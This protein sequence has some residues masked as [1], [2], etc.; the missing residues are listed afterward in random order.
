MGQGY[1]HEFLIRLDFKSF[2]ALHRQVTRLF[3]A[4]KLEEAYT[5]MIAAQGNE[6]TLKEWV[7]PWREFYE[8]DSGVGNAD[9]FLARF[10]KGI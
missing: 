4:N 7:K 5:L 9:D 3:Y 8:S 10:S 6:K 2:Y 1:S